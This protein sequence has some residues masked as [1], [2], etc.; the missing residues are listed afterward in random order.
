MFDWIAVVKIIELQNTSDR[1]RWK[2]DEDA[3]YRELGDNP[4]ERLAVIWRYL[5]GIFAA[6]AGN[7]KDRRNIRRSVSNA[8]GEV[9]D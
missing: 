4:F 6:G 8:Y 1:A 9:C 7:K 2:R 5:G 3:F